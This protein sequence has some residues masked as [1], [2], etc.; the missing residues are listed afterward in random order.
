MTNT[1]SSRRTAYKELFYYVKK[2]KTLNAFTL[3]WNALILVS[4]SLF[5]FWI[6]H[7]FP[8]YSN[9][10]ICGIILA[11][12]LARCVEKAVVDMHI[13]YREEVDMLLNELQDRCGEIEELKG[14]K[15]VDGQRWSG[16]RRGAGIAVFNKNGIHHF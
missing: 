12:Q 7:D 13:G 5:V 14:R 3:L 9:I 2:N 8:I 1:H 11:V 4:A 16:E 10:L 6:R 15:V